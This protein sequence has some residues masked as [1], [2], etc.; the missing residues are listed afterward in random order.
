[1]RIA[2]YW[3]M[4]KLPSGWATALPAA[5]NEIVNIPKISR[6]ERI[7]LSLLALLVRRERHAGALELFECSSRMIGKQHMK[8]RISCHRATEI[9]FSFFLIAEVIKDHAALIEIPCEHVIRVNI[10]AIIELAFC[11]R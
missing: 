1:M 9:V 11:Q 4:L 3:L 2:E 7:G 10:S 6:R 5:I 8:V